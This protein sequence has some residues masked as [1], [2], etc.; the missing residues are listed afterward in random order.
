MLYNT[1]RTTRAANSARLI[2]GEKGQSVFVNPRKH[3]M[4]IQKRQKLKSLLITKFMQKYGIKHPEIYLEEEINKFLQGEKLTDRDLKRLDSKIHLMLNNQKEVDNLN[5]TLNNTMNKQNLSNNNII[6]KERAQTA[7]QINVN[8]INRQ[9]KQ[10][11]T[12]ENTELKLNKYNNKYPKFKTKREELAWLEEEEKKYENKSIQILKEKVPVERIDF[13]GTGDEWGALAEYNRRIY[14]QELKEE[15][16][17][18]KEIKMRIRDELNIQIKDKVKREYEEELRNKEYIK[19][20]KE[21]LKNL[22]EMEREKEEKLRKQRKMEQEN[23]I[24]QM[25]DEYT[26]KRIA[27]LKNKKFERNLVKHYQEEIE[28]ERRKIE[29]RK[30]KEIEA[31][32]NTKK[33]NDL[34]EQKLKDDLKKE[35]EE[36]KRFM[37]EYR[38]IEEKKELERKKFFERIKKYGN[39]YDLTKAYELVEKQ[40]LEDK[41]DE[42]KINYYM[43]ENNRKELE[44]ETNKKTLKKKEERNELK[45]QLDIQIEEKKKYSELEKELDNE[46]ARIWNTDCQKYINDIKEIQQKIKKANLNNLEYL[47]RQMQDKQNKMGNKNKMSD[48]EYAMN[49]NTIKKIRDLNNKQAELA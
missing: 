13:A 9:N 11:L 49:I 25:R 1:Y 30:Q 10:N 42:D 20:W 12:E 17:K 37:E 40:K 32:L 22:E 24:N 44:K 6:K 8:N 15:K 36:D 41:E 19:I 21:H 14:E 5:F 34:R 2:S 31:Y 23:R 47:K 18:D 28:D 39:K 45:H 29:E 4:N 35:K 48:N 43:K 26:R 27:E 3:L 33:T 7:N 38:Q 46:Q 16:I